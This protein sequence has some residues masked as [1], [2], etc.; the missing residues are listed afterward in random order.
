MWGH[1]VRYLQSD[2]HY[3]LVSLG[4]DGRP[5]F[6]DYA[7]LILEVPREVDICLRWNADQIL[8]D[9]GWHQR[10]GK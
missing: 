2:E 8:T 1:P 9:A 4:R 7:S 5:D 6:D 10:C 3:L